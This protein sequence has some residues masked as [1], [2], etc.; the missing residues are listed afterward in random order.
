MRRERRERGGPFLAAVLAAHRAA[1]G[2][3]FD[4][5]EVV[6]LARPVLEAAVVAEQCEVVAGSFFDA[7]PGG[8][9]AYLLKYIL[10]D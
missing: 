7:V 1:R 5:P 3:L 9:D 2:V 4:R 6:A 10:H 8:G